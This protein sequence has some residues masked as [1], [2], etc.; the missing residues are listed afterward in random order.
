MV[1]RRSSG[2][3]T[4]IKDVLYVPCM[5]CNLLSVGQLIEKGFSVTMKNE[6]LA[7]FDAINK[8]VLRSPL[9]TKKYPSKL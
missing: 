7:L 1:I 2:S 9:S 6:V 5:K 8:L 3:S 4:I